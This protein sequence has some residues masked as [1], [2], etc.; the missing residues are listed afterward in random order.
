MSGGSG[1]PKVQQSQAA[2]A[3]TIQQ[4]AYGTPVYLL[5][6]TNRIFGNLLWYG[7]FNQVQ[8][9]V[10]GGG[11][12][13]GGVVGGGGKGGGSTEYNYYASFAI[14]MCE[15]PISAVGDV[16]ISKQISDIGTLGGQLFAGTQGQAAWGYLESNFPPAQNYTEMA[17]VGFPNFSLGTSSEMPQFS[18]ETTGLLPFDSTPDC[19]PD[20]VII[21]FLT[22]AGFPSN[23]I[24]AFTTL[25]QY[26][27]ASG[28]FISPLFD[29]Q[30]TAIDW[31]NEIMTTLNSEF[32]WSNG[33]LTAVPYGDT[34]VSNQYNT[35]TPNLNPI[36]EIGDDDWIRDGDVD[37]VTA[38]RTEAQDAYNQVPIEYVNAADQ[39]NIETY[40]A[41]DDAAV[42]LYGFRTAPTLRAHHVTN[43]QTAQIMATNWMNRQLFTRTTYTFKLPW[44]YILLDPMDYIAITDANLGLNNALVRVVSID[45]DDKE[46]LLTFTCEEVPGQIA[47]PALQPTFGATRYTANYNTDPGNINT[48]V[49]FETPLALEQ[50]AIVEVNVG[51]SGSTALWGGCQIFMSTDNLTYQYIAEFNGESRMGVLTAPIT[52]FVP[53]AGGNNIDQTNI[54]QITMAE[55]DGSFNNAA[56]PADAVNLNTLCYVDGEFIAFGNDQLTGP[57]TYSLSYL[58]RGAYGSPISAHAAGTPFVR[59]DNGVFTYEANQSYVGTQLYFKF[60]SFNVWG[61]G[62]QT[63]SEVAPFTYTVLGTALLTPLANPTNLT[64]SYT[65]NIAQLNWSPISDLRAPILYQVRKGSTFSSAQ[66]IGYTASPNFVAWGTDTYW[67]TAYYLTPFGVAVYS[68]SPPSI[69]I[70]TPALQNFL[71]ESYE[72]DPSWTGTCSGGAV[73]SGS[74][75]ILSGSGDILSDTDIITTPDVIYYGGGVTASGTYTAPSGHTISTTYVVNAK[76]MFNWTIVGSNISGADDV[77]TMSDVLTVNDILDGAAQADVYAQ[78]QIRL[79]QNGGSS[80]GAWQNWT[81]GVYQFNAIQYRINMFSLSAQIEATLSTFGIEVDVPQLTQTGSLSTSNS[82]STTVTYSK[83]FN[84]TP[85]VTGTIVS[86]QAGDL[87]VISSVGA[88]TFAVEVVNSGSAVIRTVAWTATGY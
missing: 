46:G 20:V 76:V 57:N 55:S 61:G 3:V 74:T 48:P 84:A 66:I 71:I 56:T 29:Q 9:A 35:Y 58:N 54:L 62:A 78:P 47:G 21:D 67:V 16:Y 80:Y 19:S 18:F 14:G 70:S 5:Y 23:Y 38:E 65:D 43:P 86:A 83:E 22:R 77:I 69:A 37:P 40:T 27:Q 42:D 26:C 33:V 39:Y 28:F 44:N 24:S 30:R 72:E 64:V 8:V 45:E 1:S 59:Y 73:Q 34:A 31:L 2:S 52:Q 7:A 41:F 87:L 32:V 25:Q 13:K 51:L 6:G 50:A 10:S 81:P 82:G 4:S 17:Y 11:G 63:L 60:L 36:Y 85:I 49:F 68:A 79:S 12:G 88:S 53:A 75:I 15:G